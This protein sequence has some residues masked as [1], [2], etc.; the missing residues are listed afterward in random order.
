M[1]E[2]RYN[3]LRLQLGL[4]DVPTADNIQSSLRFAEVELKD[5]LAHGKDTQAQ[6][7]AI[8]TPGK[9]S[10]KS[11]KKGSGKPADSGK[12]K[13]SCRAFDTE[14]RCPR[15]ATCKWEHPRLSVAD[16]RCFNCGVADTAHTIKNCPHPQKPAQA[17]KGAKKGAKK[18]NGKGKKGGKAH[19]QG[20]DHRRS[21]GAHYS[22]YQAC[23]QGPCY[24]RSRSG[25]TIAFHNAY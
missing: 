20:D 15:R 12:G 11:G 7:N 16:K 2:F 17:P 1:V 9:R 14:R 18:G 25:S 22:I 19:C 4:P 3:S 6:V 23:L 24:G 10:C 13:Q 8:S 5:M 21:G